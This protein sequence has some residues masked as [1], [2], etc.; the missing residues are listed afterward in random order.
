MFSENE[1]YWKRVAVRLIF[2]VCGFLTAT[3]A[4]LV[5]MLKQKMAISD[6]VMGMLLL[7]VGIGSLGFMPLSGTLARKFGCQKVITFSVTVI[8]TIL[9]A[10]C[11]NESLTLLPILL[12]IFGA[13]MGMLDVTMNLDAVI[14]ER[15]SKKNVM[16][17]F[18]GMWSVGCFAGASLFSILMTYGL[19]HWYSTVTDCIIGLV[20]F[21]SCFKHLLTYGADKDETE[22][23]GKKSIIAIP[24]GI[25]VFMGIITCIS[26]LVE[27]AIMDWSGILL[28]EVQGMDLS[29]AA[30]GFSAFSMSMLIFRL[31]GDMIVA[32][33]GE[34][35]VI[36][37]GISISIMGFLLIISGINYITTL[38]GFFLIGIGASNIVP[39][40]Y[41]QLANQKD[42]PISQAVS[43][44]SSMGYLGILM[45]PAVIGFV[46]K[47]T[48]L[49]TAFGM[50]LVLLVIQFITTR[51]VFN[52]LNNTL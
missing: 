47:A 36:M 35:P 20:V 46:S 42:M 4:P 34:K 44:A 45:G 26:F 29:L 33:L 49:Y 18:H 21:L 37:G 30:T 23:S 16:S 19:N 6:D 13:S 32:K 40:I 2:F 15:L 38:L 5:P 48:N 27:G 11:H 22:S 1:L 24:R 52:K 51:Y 8:I 39:I 7:C 31:T 28:T 43:A 12:L 9:L 41:S 25:V 3:W 14:V 50:L 17:G 10:I